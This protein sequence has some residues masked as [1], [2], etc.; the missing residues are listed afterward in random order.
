MTDKDKAAKANQWL[1]D[2]QNGWQTEMN[3]LG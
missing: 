3:L 1:S 2:Q